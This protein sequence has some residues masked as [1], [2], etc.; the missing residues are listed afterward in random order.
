MAS[1]W[2]ATESAYQNIVLKKK[3]GS[4]VINAYL[5]LL[6]AKENACLI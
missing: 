5:G 4:V 1:S 6:L 3:L 2:V